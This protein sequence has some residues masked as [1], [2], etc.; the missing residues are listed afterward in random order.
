MFDGLAVHP[1]YL[2][3]IIGIVAGCTVGLAAVIAN[4]W[5]SVRRAEV[6]AALKQDMLNRGMTVEQIERV[7]RASNVSEEGGKTDPISDNE[8]HLV[9][10][11][12]DE[13]RS[14][15][16]IE[17]VIRAFKGTPASD[18]G[19]KNYPMNVMP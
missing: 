14:T 3:P 11:M 18:A 2:I 4:N 13:G 7:V 12:V 10:R 19:K 15:E 8:M 17:R 5:R 9:E 6:E 16:E 1:E